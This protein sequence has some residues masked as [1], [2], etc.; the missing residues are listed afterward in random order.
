MN[1]NQRIAFNS[2]IIYVRLVLVS[3]L[4]LSVVRTMSQ[5]FEESMMQKGR[6]SSMPAMPLSMQHVPQVSFPLIQ[7]TSK[8]MIL[9]IWRRTSSSPRISASKE[10]LSSIPRNSPSSI[11]TS[12][13]QRKKWPGQLKWFNC[14]QK[15]KQ[16]VKV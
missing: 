8:S 3:S 13:R 16:K 10:C 12:P 14:Q 5:T 7:C 1:D 4:L 11:N 6:A 9:K 15:P 2:I